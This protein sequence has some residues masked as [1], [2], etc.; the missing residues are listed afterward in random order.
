MF[1]YIFGLT[2][3]SHYW[4]DLSRSRFLMGPDIKVVYVPHKNL[5]FVNNKKSNDLT[6]ATIFAWQIRIL[7]H[8]MVVINAK[9]SVFIY[10]FIYLLKNGIS[11]DISP[12]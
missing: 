9:S 3:G 1:V 10:L 6:S 2:V 8:T 7:N 5:L 4:E 12:H 11:T